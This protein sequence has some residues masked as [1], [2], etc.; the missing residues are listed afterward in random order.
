MP[1]LFTAF[2]QSKQLAAYMRA[3]GAVVTEGAQPPSVRNVNILLVSK[4]H[5]LVRGLEGTASAFNVNEYLVA[6]VHVL[7]EAFLAAVQASPAGKLHVEHLEKEH[8]HA[9]V[10]AEGELCGVLSC[11]QGP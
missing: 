5:V 6:G 11:G 4:D 3:Q 1:R 10:Y 8:P 7:T 2:V 9:Q